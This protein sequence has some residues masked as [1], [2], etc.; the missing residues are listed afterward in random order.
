MNSGFVLGFVL[1]E[2]NTWT[3]LPFTF[4]GT[5]YTSSLN[6]TY[7][8]HTSTNN[9]NFRILNSDSDF[10]A[11]SFAN[12]VL[13]FRVVIFSGGTGSRIDKAAL[14]KMSWEELEKYL[15]IK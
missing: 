2:A 14:Q 3:P 10:L 1:Y 11:P 9:L 15:K 7:S 4:F 13:S 8:A 12:E 6:F 5:G